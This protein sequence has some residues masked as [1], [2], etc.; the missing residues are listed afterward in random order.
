[1]T[2]RLGVIGAGFIAGVHLS[3][4]QNIEGV[5]LKGITDLRP[6]RAQA[7][8]DKYGIEKVYD[9][10]DALIQAND[11]DAVIVA[12]ANRYHAEHAIKALQQGKH[13]LCEK[14]MALNSSQ[15]REI[16]KTQ[17][18]TGRT[19]MVAH[20]MRWEGI[21]QTIKQ[22]IDKGELGKIYNAK[23]GWWRR[24]GIPGW[25]SWFTRMEESGGG[26]LI[27]IGVHM[28]DLS[29][30]LMGNPRPVAV[31]G[32][33]YAEFGPRKMGI[34][35][36]GTPEWDG[37]FNVEDLATALIKMDN[38]A[39]LTLEVS[40]A[41]NTDSTQKP[42]INLMGTEGG[43][44][45]YGGRGVFCGQKFGRPFD[46]EITSSNVDARLNLSQHFIDCIREGK[47]P[48]SP[49]VSGFANNLII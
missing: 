46:V 14:P 22:Q 4:F 10:A 2:I 1:M 12:S 19:L 28:L 8:K 5:V 44:S 11:I 3:K 27:D 42:F 35:G 16:V 48:I 40:W 25:G 38:G 7:L 36:W 34:G 47:E 29:I 21:S 32:S 33:T 13:V 39:T 31:F 15:A 17:K 49:A 43:A 30:W 9:S 18:S 20:Q 6:E 26:P 24:C 45:Y 41:V 37:V 23:A